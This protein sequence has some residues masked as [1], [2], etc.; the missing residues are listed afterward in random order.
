M[1]GRTMADPRHTS[2]KVLAAVALLGWALALTG[3][4]HALAQRS[5]MHWTSVRVL[6]G[7]DPSVASARPHAVDRGGTYHLAREWRPGLVA[8]TDGLAQP[9]LSRVHLAAGETIGFAL[10]DAGQIIAVA[11]DRQEVLIP[12]D[13]VHYVWYRPGNDVADG[14]SDVAVFTGQVVLGVVVLA[15]LI[16]LDGLSD[17]DHHVHAYGSVCYRH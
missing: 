13:E 15:G 10:N 16:L 11:G 4:N 7:D 12:T 6:P 14:I 2:G 17:H 1:M 3:C 9:R 8:P 5:A